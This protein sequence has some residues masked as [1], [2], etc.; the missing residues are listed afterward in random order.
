M[1]VM[2]E[3]NWN[4]PI[5]SFHKSREKRRRRKKLWKNIRRQ[6]RSTQW[7]HCIVPI[8]W[9]NRDFFAEKCSSESN[10]SS[11]VALR[12]FLTPSDPIIFFF[13]PW[14]H[15]ASMLCLVKMCSLN[16]SREKL[17]FAF[18]RLFTRSLMKRKRATA[19][20]LHDEASENRSLSNYCKQRESIG[21]KELLGDE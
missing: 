20:T 17:Y 19:S 8:G 12:H 11:A 3:E 5:F 13:I 9:R 1:V 21:L 15:G 14:R 7:C 6:A 10:E 2:K 16:L 18:E 4:F